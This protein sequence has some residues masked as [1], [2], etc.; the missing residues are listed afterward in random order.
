MSNQCFIVGNGPSLKIEDLEKLRD[1][2]CFAVN[3]IHLWYDQTDWRPNVWVSDD[4]WKAVD[5]GGDFMF[6]AN[7][8][9]DIWV[10]DTML[11]DFADTSRT[12]PYHK[13]GVLFQP[14]QRWFDIPNL[15][16]YHDC[17]HQLEYRGEAPPPWHLPHLCSYGWSVYICAQLAVLQ[18]FDEIV[19]IGC[20]GHYTQSGV[21]HMHPEYAVRK[22]PDGER[23]EWSD[24]W[25]EA[26]NIHMQYGHC[27]I[28][29][30]CKDR[31]IRVINASRQT[32][33]V[34]HE[35][36]TLEAVLKG[37]D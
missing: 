16:I 18:G 4:S 14:R 21:N 8:G 31:G 25:G 29:K 17:L 6:H 15:H 2:F 37:S 11:Y 24:G 22:N 3:R 12:D 5:W 32:A 9:Y 10:R 13:S 34:D 23:V 20:D 33:I 1:K 28:E 35:R 19:F 36:Q 27:R 7:Q 26:R 30:E